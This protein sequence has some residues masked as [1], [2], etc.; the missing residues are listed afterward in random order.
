MSEQK[1]KKKRISWFSAV[2]HWNKTNNTVKHMNPKKGT[3]QYLEVKAI[4]EK[5]KAGTLAAP[6]SKTPYK[7]RKKKTEKSVTIEV[8][9]EPD[10]EG[11]TVEVKC[12]GETKEEKHEG[13]EEHIK[14]IKELKQKLADVKRPV[15]PHPVKEEKKKEVKTKAKAPVLPT[16]PE[17]KEPG[18]AKPEIKPVKVAKPKKEKKTAEQKAQ[19][20][21]DKQ[22]AKKRVKL[23]DLVEQAKRQ[24][25]IID[26]MG[27]KISFESAR[28][29]DLDKVSSTLFKNQETAMKQK[30]KLEAKINELR[31]E[32]GIEESFFKLTKDRPKPER[33]VFRK[34]EK[35]AVQEKEAE[36]ARQREQEKEEKAAESATKAVQA[37]I[38]KIKEKNPENKNIDALVK[39]R[40]EARNLE[41]RNLQTDRLDV[42][43]KIRQEARKLEAKKDSVER[44]AKVSAER[45]ND[46]V[47]LREKKRELLTKADR[48]KFTKNLLTQSKQEKEDQRIA[49]KQ[50]KKEGNGKTK[51]EMEK[52]RSANRLKL[53]REILEK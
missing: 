15:T 13:A 17:G 12:D 23:G 19:E 34:S 21:L 14:E 46:L 9:C 26:D 7:S 47:E 52:I 53:I 5:M 20:K 18:P 28:L 11:V 27:N 37:T 10:K 33:K 44:E 29:G 38:A 41:A 24:L 43:I 48:L 4:F 39:I 35:Q 6:E 1:V 45:L 25:F 31:N 42:L 32:L 8:K 22:K 49:L 50:M 36:A 2:S 3:A 16:I 51:L 40:E 30:K